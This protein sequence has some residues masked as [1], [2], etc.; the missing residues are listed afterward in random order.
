MASKLFEGLQ[1]SKNY[2]IFRPVPPKSL[3]Q[4]IVDFIGKD[5]VRNSFF[6]K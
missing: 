6:V 4:K 3:V 1:H 5:K 2:A